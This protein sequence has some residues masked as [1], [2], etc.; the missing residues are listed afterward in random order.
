M[1][2]KFITTKAAV[3]ELDIPMDNRRVWSNVKRSTPY[4]VTHILTDGNGAFVLYHQF[5]QHEVF[6]VEYISK[7][8]ERLLNELRRR[9][10]LAHNKSECPDIYR[11][12]EYGVSNADIGYTCR[13]HTAVSAREFDPTESVPIARVLLCYYRYVLSIGNPYKLEKFQ[14]ALEN[15]ILGE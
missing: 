1:G 11:Y 5:P 10:F 7:A 6:C 4:R 15:I 9:C 13:C 3:M 8:D 14:L 12:G 2:Y